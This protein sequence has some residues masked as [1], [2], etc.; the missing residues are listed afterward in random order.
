VVC[1]NCGLCISDCGLN[2]SS[3]TALRESRSQ[4]TIRNPHSAM[5]F[6]APAGGSSQRLQGNSVAFSP[7]AT[8]SNTGNASRTPVVLKMFLI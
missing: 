4:S 7:L 6:R 3:N 2:L 1:S 8:V 5:H